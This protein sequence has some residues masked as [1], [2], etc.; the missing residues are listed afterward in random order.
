MTGIID[1]AHGA[2]VLSLRVTLKIARVRFKI[3][4]RVLFYANPASRTV[5]LLPLLVQD[6]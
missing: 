3:S 1:R 4:L 2:T 5:L 6:Y